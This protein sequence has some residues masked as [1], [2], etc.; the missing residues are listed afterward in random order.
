MIISPFVP[1]A[2]VAASLAALVPWAVSAGATSSTV[3]SQ[4][5][6]VV[7]STRDRVSGASA[8]PPNSSD[9]LDPGST[10]P[11]SSEPQL[12]AQIL[13]LS[14]WEVTLPV[15][16][17]GVPDGQ[18]D[19]SEVSQPELASFSDDYFQSDSA[20]DG[21]TFMA[22]IDGSTTTGSFYPRSELREMN[23]RKHASW[24]T[25]R[26]T[27]TMVV[28][29]SVDS[30][31]AVKQQVVFAQL[32]GSSDDVFEAEMSRSDTMGYVLDVNH[33]GDQWGSDLDDNYELGTK[34]TLVI[35]ASGGYIDVYF[36]GDRKVQEANSTRHDYFKVGA[37]TQSNECTEGGQQA[38]CSS[39]K[40]DDHSFGQVTVYL[41]AVTH[42]R[43]VD[44]CTPTSS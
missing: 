43:R 27:S 6:Q 8:V 41:L 17:Q 19:A 44:H 26:G 35:V 10:K 15:N 36:N 28:T 34:F 12:P 42:C 32:H 7:P 30:A 39:G 13:D 9:R 20:G 21:V 40:V 4:R 16:S 3:G 31:P 23:G 2:V 37:Y 24:S 22:P 18:K 38:D 14:N 33:N 29:E 25:T 11:L 5:L 1:K